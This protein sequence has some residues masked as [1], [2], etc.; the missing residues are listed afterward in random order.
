MQLAHVRSI[1]YQQKIEAAQAALEQATGNL[2]SAKANQ[3]LAATDYARAQV[4]FSQQST[5]KRDY[6]H[7]VQQRDFANGAVAQAQA[8]VA[9]QNAALDQ[10]K[11]ALHDTAIVAPFDGVVISRQVELGNL[12]VTNAPAFTVADIHLLKANFTVPDTMLH[13]IHQGAKLSVSVPSPS[14]PVPATITAVSSSADSQTRVFTVEITID[15]SHN[16]Y[17]PGMI[18]TV[19]LN[20]VEDAQQ[21]LAVPLDA[22]VR[23]SGSNMFAVYTTHSENGSTRAVLQP[24]SIGRSIGNNI[25]ILQGLS[26]SQRIVMSGA[27]FLHNN[28]EVRVVE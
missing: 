8:S 15:N 25:E 23:G 19:V 2:N 6:D 17:K 26:A 14:E 10:A 24:V 20:Q 1:D 28:D 22:L 27:Q 11:L 12:S 7:A 16:L 21:H 18:G 9:N 4:L 5:T 3:Q 13:E